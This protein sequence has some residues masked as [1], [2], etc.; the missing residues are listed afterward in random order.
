[1]AEARQAIR[2][3]GANGGYTMK[4]ASL[5]SEHADTLLDR[6]SIPKAELGAAKDH[7]ETLVKR[8]GTSF[9]WGM[10]LLPPA[11]RE[12]M[13]AIYAFCREV[14]DIADCDMPPDDKLRDLNAWREAIEA[15]YRGCPGRPTTFALL[16]P[17]SEFDLPKSEFLHMI[18]GMEMDARALMI[19]PTMIDLD[20]Y[21]RAVAGTVGLLSM[22]VFGQRS[23]ELD[24]GALA[25][26]EALQLTNILRDVHEDAKLQRLYLPR[27]L[28][29]QYGIKPH[30]PIDVIRHPEIKGV[31][32]ALASRAEKCF[33]LSDRLL[34]KGDRGKLR[35][36]LIMMHSYRRIL[37]RLKQ[38]DWQ[39]LERRERLS[40]IERLWIG[41]RHGWL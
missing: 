40:K 9:Y 33:A 38:K 29:V 32:R 25:L 34:A 35:P 11:K 12:A 17:V 30:S 41:I 19:A 16:G 31:C 27:E 22:S 2:P 39:R 28:L 24:R 1:M 5:R 4:G 36:A 14:D 10:R 26:A 18:D 20:R 6:Q 37:A 8:S 15:L 3:S 21:C 23:S 13:F 7:V